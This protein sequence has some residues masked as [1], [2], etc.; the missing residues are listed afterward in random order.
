MLLIHSFTHPLT[1][2]D[3]QGQGLE[4]YTFSLQAELNHRGYG[5]LSKLGKYLAETAHPPLMTVASYFTSDTFPVDDSFSS[6]FLIPISYA[7]LGWNEPVGLP[8]IIFF[9]LLLVPALIVAIFFASLIARD[10]NHRGLSKSAVRCWIAAALAFGLTAYLTHLLIRP[11]ITLIT[12]PN[13]GKPLRPDQ[14]HCH[15][16][17]APWSLPH[18]KSPTWRVVDT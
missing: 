14:S 16:C 1:A 3:R 9:V 18:L 8:N 13:C 5:P 17:D 15:R 7:A 2:F 12:C 6:M 11:N 4:G 10:A